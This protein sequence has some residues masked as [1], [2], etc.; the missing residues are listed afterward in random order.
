MATGRP[1]ITTNAPGCRQTVEDGVNG[2]LVEPKSVAA[3]AEAM[4]RFIVQPALIARMVDAS[5]A[6]VRDEF[7][8]RRVNQAI[9]AIIYG[10]DFGRARV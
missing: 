2:F 9:Q 6:K 3:V 4:R 7:D 10:G 5:L 8:V 1:V